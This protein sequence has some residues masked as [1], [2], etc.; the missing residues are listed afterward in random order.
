MFIEEEAKGVQHPH[1]E[2][3]VVTFSI[4]NFSTR[5][6]L[7]DNGSSANIFFLPAFDLMDLG[8]DNLHPV[9]CSAAH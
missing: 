6:I 5:R 8:R 9:S 3:F 4:A 1:D 7:I 2:A